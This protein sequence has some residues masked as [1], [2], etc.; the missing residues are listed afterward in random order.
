MSAQVVMSETS[1]ESIAGSDGIGHRYSQP[2]VL[3]SFFFGDQEAAARTARDRYQTQIAKPQQPLGKGFV[4]SDAEL[5]QIGHLQQFLVVELDDVRVLEGPAQQ[6]LA[7]KGFAQVD[8]AYSQ[9]VLGCLFQK[10]LDGRRGHF[11]TLRQRSKTDDVS[12]CRELLQ[13]R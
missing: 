10:L 7:V 1:S 9:R 6:T 2:F 3:N 4:R 12:C 8:V 13:L 11:G 5:E